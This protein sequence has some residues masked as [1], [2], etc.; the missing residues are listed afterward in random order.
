MNSRWCAWALPEVTEGVLREAFARQGLVWEGCLHVAATGSLAK[1]MR[2]TGTPA[3]SIA[4]LLDIVAWS[5]MPAD[6]AKD[7]SEFPSLTSVVDGRVKEFDAALKQ[8]SNEIAGRHLSLG[9]SAD[10][11]LRRFL[12]TD[13]PDREASRVLRRAVRDLRRSVQAAAT[14]G[15]Q[16]DDFEDADAVPR[17]ALAAW[18]RLDT[19]LPELF[20]LRDD[21]WIDPEEFADGS[22]PRAVQLRERIEAILDQLLAGPGGRWTIAYHGFYFFTPHQ[23]A[24]FQLLR[25]HGKIDQHFIVHDDGSGR[26]FETWRR[27]FDERWEMPRPESV[28]GLTP[29]ATPDGS[30]ARALAAALSGSDVPASTKSQ[31]TRL[32]ECTSSTEFIELWR[33]QRSKALADDRPKPVLFAAGAGD[34]ERMVQRL[35]FDP[36]TAAVNLAELPIGQFLLALHSCVETRADGRHRLVLNRAQLVDM[37]AS[38]LLDVGHSERDP[39]VHV[40]AF[41]RAMPFF[42]DCTLLADWV[43]RAQVLERLVV[44]EVSAFGQRTTG[45][46][47]RQRIQ[48]AVSNP[49]RLVPWA[50]LSELE[51][52]VVRETIGRVTEL[53][54]RVMSAEGRDPNQYL[55][56]I[57]EQLRRGMANLPPE[58]RRVVEDKLRG[59]GTM[60]EG[61]FDVEGII[62]VVHLLL[63]RQAEFGFDGDSENDSVVARELRNLD[64]LGFAPSRADVHIANLV[65]TE[66]PARFQAFRWPFVERLLKPSRQISTVSVEIFRTR[67]ETAALSDLYLF[68]LALCGVDSSATLTLSWIA[69]MGN[70]IRNP[71]SLVMLIAALDH[72]E[73]VLRDAVGGLVV[74]RA[75]QSMKLPADRTLPALR[76]PQCTNEE[77]ISAISQLDP[78]ATSASFVCARRFALQWAM[79]PS[80]AFQTAHTQRM[81]FGNVQG[82]LEK[83][84]RWAVAPSAAIRLTKDLWRQFTRGER[85]S[86]QKKRVVNPSGGAPW[87][88]IYTLGGQGKG[89]DGLSMAYQA[90]RDGSHPLPETIVPLGGVLPTPTVSERACNMCPVKP[91]CALHVSLRD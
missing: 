42:D 88:W 32:V 77:L 63:G 56:W 50:D 16:P 10:L 64:A 48:V 20:R 65:D 81:L 91:R 79:G 86:S 5:G 78:S 84:R 44:S 28:S 30:R 14:A 29:P 68:W 23:W 34:I 67:E 52:S 61:E 21:V 66:F 11:R 70:E 17:V 74:E 58:E 37:V 27:Y 31:P 62:D 85:M 90:A 18:R 54:E 55:G 47:D 89:T 72:K 75:D 7:P 2:R 69:E 24:W 8:W 40:A 3:L 51:V 13:A 59:V 33:L 73:K 76:A 49:L 6:R 35:D 39:S 53:A 45:L 41:E 36:S 80:G 4:T 83:N 57:R 19:E 15:F 22:T 12:D 43:A 1:A 46:T 87:E 25:S 71:S 9:V 26:A 82:A 38:R 60:S